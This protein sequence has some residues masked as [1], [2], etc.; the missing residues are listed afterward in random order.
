[1]HVCENECAVFL[2]SSGL[3]QTSI[4]HHEDG[5][6]GNF[7]V[8][9]STHRTRE[10]T[11]AVKHHPVRTQRI[12]Q[13]PAVDVASTLPASK[14]LFN[15]DRLNRLFGKSKFVIGGPARRRRGLYIVALCDWTLRT[16]VLE[17]SSKVVTVLYGVFGWRQIAKRK[18]GEGN[19]A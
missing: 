4:V 11:V 2:D 14:T 10:L 8:V 6:S 13:A 9:D 18:L 16:F 1:M 19:T 12:G 15:F 17:R 7:G 3:N 5:H